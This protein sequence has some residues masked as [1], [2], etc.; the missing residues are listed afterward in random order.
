MSFLR[1]RRCVKTTQSHRES[2]LIDSEHFYPGAFRVLASGRRATEAVA[3]HRA[4]RKLP[5][6][7]NIS[8][9]WP[10]SQASALRQHEISYAPSRCDCAVVERTGETSCGTQALPSA[11]WQTSERLGVPPSDHSVTASPC[12]SSATPSA[13]TSKTCCSNRVV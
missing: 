3:S 8:P 12:A 13:A 2:N 1:G 7:D 9:L 10:G 6:V 4:Q 5:L 11:M